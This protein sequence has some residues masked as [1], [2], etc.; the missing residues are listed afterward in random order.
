MTRLCAMLLGAALALALIVCMQLP[1]MHPTSTAV[2]SLRV[3]DTTRAKIAW[4][5]SGSAALIVPSLGIT[6]NH[7]NSPMPIASL[8]KM[9]TAYVVLKKLPLSIGQ[10]GPCVTVSASDV[11]TYEAMIQTDQ[12]NALVS[13]GEQLCESELLDGL[14]VH[15]ANNYSVMLANM[16]AGSSANFVALMN[17]TAASMGFVGTHYVDPS[18]YDPGSVSTAL[19]QG[20]LAERLMKSPL[21]RS[22]VAQTSVT[23][24]VAGT[25]GSYTPY[26]GIDHVI[27]VKSGR[28]LAAGG[29]DVMAMQ[30]LDGARLRTVYSVV[31]DQRGGDLL[32][33]AGDAALALAQSAVAGERSL[34]LAKGDV[35]GRIGWAK[36]APVLTARASSF[37]WWPVQGSLPV[38]VVFAHF[39]NPIRRGQRVGWLIVH[40]KHLERIALVAGESVSPPSLW[41]RLR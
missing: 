4:P 41:Q 36:S 37:H 12:S 5:E 33:P 24:P 29:C 38:S 28:T 7:N 21:V 34:S 10:T 9:M 22:I 6:L 32:G 27:G 8:T 19:D 14:L 31:L 11:A 25:V 16:V 39:S 3:P 35:V 26:V 23:L 17:Q 30:F 18:G 40:A 20:L 13:V 1:L 2:L 15:S